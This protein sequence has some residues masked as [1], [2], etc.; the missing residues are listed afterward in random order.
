[1]ESFVKSSRPSPSQLGQLFEL[2][3]ARQKPFSGISARSLCFWV[4]IN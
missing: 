3:T 4:E 1:M 2:Q